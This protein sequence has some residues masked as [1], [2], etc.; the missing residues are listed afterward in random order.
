MI[1]INSVVS[2]GKFENNIVTYSCKIIE[3]IDGYSIENIKFAYIPPH[4]VMFSE[5]LRMEPFL[6]YFMIQSNAEG[7]PFDDFLLTGQ[8][9]EMRFATFYE[10]NQLQNFIKL[11]KA[12]D[13]ANRKSPSLKGFDWKKVT[14]LALERFKTTSIPFIFGRSDLGS[15]ISQLPKEVV[16]YIL[17]SSI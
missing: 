6:Q 8:S 16:A 4:H 15:F 12:H 7:I 3:G 13:I 1:P 14:E 17:N 10:I 5:Y 9:L 2:S 11:G